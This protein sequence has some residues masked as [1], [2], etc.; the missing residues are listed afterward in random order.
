MSEI[1]VLYS[2]SKDRRSYYEDAG[3]MRGLSDQSNAVTRRYVRSALTT[4]G[5]LFGS[6][7]D[8]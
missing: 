6:S 2:E 5:R 3:A 8:R 7:Q 4:I 1:E